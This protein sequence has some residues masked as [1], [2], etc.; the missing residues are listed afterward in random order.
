MTGSESHLLRKG[1][2][3]DALFA[4]DRVELSPVTKSSVCWDLRTFAAPQSPVHDRIPVL[5]INRPAQPF[6]LFSASNEHRD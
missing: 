5:T 4:G 6:L 2:L 3:Q 1:Y